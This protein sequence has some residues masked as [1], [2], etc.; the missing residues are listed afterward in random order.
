MKIKK[1]DIIIL[2][3]CILVFGLLT[4]FVRYNGNDGDYILVSVDGAEY[5]KLSLDDEGEYEID[6]FNEGKN[7]IVIEKG[8]AKIIEANCPDGL[9]MSQK[10]ISAD[11]ETICCLPNRVFI[12]VISDTDKEVDAIAR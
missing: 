4:F 12:E 2:I 8:E 3:S 7:V 10:P 6:G 9:C 5:K 1:S 11:G